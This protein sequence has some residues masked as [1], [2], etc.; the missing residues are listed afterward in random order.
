MRFGVGSFCEIVDSFSSGVPLHET[1]YAFGT[2]LQLRSQI[3]LGRISTY[4]CR[5]SP[6]V[7][8]RR[9]HTECGT[10]YVETNDES[11]SQA[12]LYSHLTE[13]G[14]RTGIIARSKRGPPPARGGEGSVVRYHHHH[15]HHHQLLTTSSS[16]QSG[17]RFVRGSS[18]LWTISDFNSFQDRFQDRHVSRPLRP[19]PAGIAPLTQILAQPGA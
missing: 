10:G 6:V 15:H 7:Q 2:S 16:A 9:T 19:V 17:V 11:H 4:S 18:A 14:L 8:A 13:T 5:R 1:R 3:S 12:T